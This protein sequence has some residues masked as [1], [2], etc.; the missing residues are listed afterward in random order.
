MAI[1]V[2][3]VSASSGAWAARSKPAAGRLARGGDASNIGGHG[4]ESR[5]SGRYP[6]NVCPKRM[7][8]GSVA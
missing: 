8:S 6:A 1:I 2:D 7:T 3:D 4:G 5:R